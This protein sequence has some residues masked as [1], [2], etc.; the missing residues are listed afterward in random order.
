MSIYRK[1]TESERELLSLVASKGG[2]MN[3]EDESLAPFC[4]DDSTLTAP[5]A[6]NACHDMDWLRS[7]H[8]HDRDNS[9]VQITDKGR[10]ALFTAD[11]LRN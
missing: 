4:S 3:H 2:L 1:P 10:E 9:I 5:D 8:D 11:A 6:F 7:L